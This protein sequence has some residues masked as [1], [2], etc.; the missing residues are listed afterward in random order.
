MLAGAALQFSNPR[1]WTSVD[2]LRGLLFFVQRIEELTFS[3][4]NDSFKSHTTSIRGLISEVIDALEKSISFPAQAKHAEHIFDELVLRIRG[5]KVVSTLLNRPIDSYVKINLSD[6]DGSITALRNL[7]AEIGHGPFLAA[8]VE[9]VRA[10]STDGRAK[11]ELDNLAREFVATLQ[12]SGVSREY[13]YRTT[14]ETFFASERIQSADIMLKFIQD[15]YPHFHRY[16]VYCIVDNKFTQLGEDAL[17]AFGISVIHDVK[18]IANRHFHG[19]FLRELERSQ[20]ATVA[21]K[22]SAM[23]YYS[24]VANAN[25]QI[26][27]LSSIYQI[28][29]HKWKHE[30]ADISIAEQQCCSNILKG[31]QA[32]NNAMHFIKDKKPIPAIE[33][34]NSTIESVSFVGGR[35][36]SRYLNLISMHGL[37][38]SSSTPDSQLINL[39]TC[40]ETIVPPK[41]PH[42]DISNVNHVINNILP[43]IGLTYLKKISVCLLMDLLR[44]DRKKLGEAFRLYG[45][46]EKGDTDRRL[47]R[48][49]ADINNEAGINYL[50]AELDNFELLRFRLFDLAKLFRSKDRMIGRI[51]RHEQNIKW[52]LH[53]IYRARNAIV[54]EGNP[55][56][57]VRYL[58]ENAHEYYDRSFEFCM[59]LSASMPEFNSFEM[60]FKFAQDQ[61]DYY[62]RNISD[63]CTSM[64]SIWNLK[65]NKGKHYLFML[66]QDA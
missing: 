61:Y 52:Q 21:V 32:P 22:A 48:L 43:I 4:T 17:S 14:R 47:V 54:H 39:W 3:Y 13:I 38:N 36:K 23:D 34:L 31:V 63:G 20:G 62:L 60:C 58:V 49:I 1:N 37:S 30:L 24:A 16:T 55:P 11:K 29:H 18:S 41:D 27:A 12:N 56:E 35:D 40:L 51:K 50:L 7:R 44:W 57:S 59:R 26:S 45:D 42:K 46:D 9:R 33:E 15:V 6:V 10:L 25:Q 2:N 5:C 65:S 66:A 64:D 19:K 8:I 28:F 53:R